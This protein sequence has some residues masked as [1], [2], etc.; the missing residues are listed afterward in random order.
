M[1]DSG[2]SG[3]CEDIGEQ[4]RTAANSIALLHALLHLGEPRFDMIDTA[5]N[6]SGRDHLPPLEYFDALYASTAARL[7]R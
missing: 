4:M 1:S 3:A 5:P 7:E 2:R 6:S